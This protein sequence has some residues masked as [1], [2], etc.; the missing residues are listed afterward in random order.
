CFL[1]FLIEN[2]YL[3]ICLGMKLCAPPHTCGEERPWL[4][5]RSDY[6]GHV[7]FYR[8]FIKNF[9]ILALPLSR[10]LQMDVEFNFD[11]PCIEAFQELKNRLTS[12]YVLQAPNWDLAFELMCD[13][14]NLALGAVLGQRAGV[15]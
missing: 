8:I 2:F 6:L 12:A 10:L 9:S 11:Q 15:G 14:S 3:A 13:A 4:Y 1:D 7:G 5:C